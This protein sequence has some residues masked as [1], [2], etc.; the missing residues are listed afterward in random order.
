M[1]PRGAPGEMERLTA[2]I[3]DL[4]G[5]LLDDYRYNIEA[6]RKVFMRYGLDVPAEEIGAWFGKPT[7]Y[8]IEQILTQRGIA[9]NWAELA[10]EKVR[11]Y[12]ALTAGRTLFA[13][14][15]VETLETLRKHFRLAMFTGVT[16]KQVELLGDFLRFF[17][18][19]V[20]GEEAIRPKPDPATLLFI[21]Q[22]MGIEP[23]RCAYVGDMPQDMV[24]A[25]N[26]GMAGI[27][28]ESPLFSR[29][30]LL[31]AGAV[32]VARRIDELPGLLAG[33]DPPSLQNGP[34]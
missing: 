30:D 24:L 7:S 11:N 28:I 13:P 18:V 6:F 5:T 10:Q 8:I 31:G 3:F 15:A 16:R 33:T 9:A 26:A 19:I 22:R 21:A 17:E 27:G 14:G 29:E 2:L 1:K 20:A 32:K 25:R 23:F 12:V 4:N 34:R